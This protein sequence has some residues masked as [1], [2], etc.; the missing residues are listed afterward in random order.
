M[1]RKGKP[2]VIGGGPQFVDLAI[3]ALIAVAI[4][5]VAFIICAWVRP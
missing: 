3:G 1:P 5:G 4:I 2:I